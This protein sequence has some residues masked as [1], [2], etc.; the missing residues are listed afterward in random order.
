MA[1]MGSYREQ[2]GRE[3]W[4]VPGFSWQQL[5]RVSTIA[6]GKAETGVSVA[7]ER[8]TTPGPQQNTAHDKFSD[9]VWS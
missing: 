1:Q 9:D 6:Q 8:T 3:A 2:S 4:G 7:S 5:A